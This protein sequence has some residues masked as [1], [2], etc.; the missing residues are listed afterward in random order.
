V[1]EIV[2]FFLQNPQLK[3]AVTKNKRKH[4]DGEENE[5]D[6]LGEEDD[7]LKANN[8]LINISLL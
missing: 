5:D 6:L 2:L 8:M 3:A 1:S 4:G 7:E